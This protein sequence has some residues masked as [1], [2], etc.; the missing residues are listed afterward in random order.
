MKRQKWI[1]TIGMIALLLIIAACGG[2]AQPAKVAEADQASTTQAAPVAETESEAAPQTRTVSTA[3]GDIDIP[4][5]P[6]RVI[7]LSVVYPDFLYALDIIPVAVQ[8]YHEELPTYL[9]DPLKD[10]IKMGISRTP[11]FEAI[12]AAQPDLI[13]APTWWSEADYDQLSKI[14]P[15]VLLPERDNW[16]DELRDIAEV[17]DRADKAEQVISDLD[18]KKEQAAKELDE[19]AGDQT[20]MYMRVMAKEIVI[21]GENI[22]RGNLIHKQLG[23]NPVPDF[24]QTEATM[25]ISL[26]KLPDYDADHIIVQLDNDG[27]EVKERFDE[28][29]SSSL[30]QGMT[31]VK[32]DHIH[33][34]NDREWFNVGMSPLADSN[35]IDDV[36]GFFK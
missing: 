7:G 24:P 6:Q 32:N 9:R 3:K 10:T 4:A 17:F 25:S 12:L 36:L 18:A 23:L 20:V 2:S 19:L 26:E 28:I 21:S 29:L 11:D 15:T 1:M 30:W 8:N 16:Q 34:V 27:P 31:A 5:D 35:A 13:L 33:T 14:A 22:D